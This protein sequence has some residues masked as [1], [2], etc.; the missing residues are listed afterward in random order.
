MFENKPVWVGK[1]ES[2]HVDTSV[3]A[4]VCSMTEHL[5]MLK[6]NFPWIPAENS[7]HCG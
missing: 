3:T 6:D 4:M 2:I 5:D 7:F 1:A